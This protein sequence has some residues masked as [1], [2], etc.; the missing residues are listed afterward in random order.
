MNFQTQLAPSHQ[1][2][3]SKFRWKGG[4][5]LGQEKTLSNEKQP[6]PLD[7]DQPSHGRQLPQQ[8]LSMS[9]MAIFRLLC[10]FVL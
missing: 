7:S 8:P 3:S 4:D 10:P 5:W 9:V 6:N 2:R 1:N